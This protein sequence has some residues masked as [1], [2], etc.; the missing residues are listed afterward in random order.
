M[1]PGMGDDFRAR[2]V[3]SALDGTNPTVLAELGASFAVMGD[4]QFLPGY[5]V[6]FTKDP[7]VRQLADLPRPGRLAFLADVDLVATAVG[8]VCAATD[9]QFWRINIE[10]EGNTD[11]FL[12]AYIW[13]RYAWEP[14]QRRRKPVWL[15][16]DCRWERPED[17]LGPR[18]DALRAAVT[19]E[20]VR[21]RDS[22]EFAVFG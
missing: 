9:S 21:L 12:H 5:C 17:R 15:Y 20:I 6:V 22:P 18:Q 19:A 8:T 1:M 3:E 11:A 7:S 10:I 13:P 2:R 14:G 16:P 4:V